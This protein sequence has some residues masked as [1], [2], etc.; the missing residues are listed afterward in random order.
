MKLD[1]LR[2]LRFSY[3]AVGS[4]QYDETPPGYHRLDHRVR[5]GS[6]DDAFRRAGEA[7]MTWQAHRAAGVPVKA[8]DSP[9]VIGTNS[10]GRLGVG[11]FGLPAPC[12]VVWVV[13]EPDRTG[14]AYG[15]LAGH[16]QEGEESMVVTR[17]PDGIYYT[18]RAYSRGGTWYSR[19]GGPLTRRAQLL[20][21]KHYAKALQ[22]LASA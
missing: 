18:I 6:G 1:D 5:I 17:E 22:R 20:V 19:L 11:D 16:P 12:R 15:T 10:L 3:D 14:F 4:T 8:T 13:D 7:L 2:D 21:A 9:L